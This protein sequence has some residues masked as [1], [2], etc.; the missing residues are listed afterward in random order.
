MPNLLEIPFKRTHNVPIRQT[1]REYI[2]ANH[3]DVHPDAFKWDINQWGTLRKQAVDRTV[4]VDHVKV[5]L[6]YHAQLVFILTKLPVDIGLDIPYTPLFSPDGPP[7]TLRNLAYERAAVLFNLAALYSQLAHREDRSTADGLKR[8]VAYFQSAAGTLSHLSTSAAQKLEASVADN[9]TI[10]EFSAPFLSALENLMLA[11]AQEGVWQRAVIDNLKNGVIAKLAAKAASF[12]RSTLQTIREASPAVMHLFPASW[13]A[14]VEI[15]ASHFEGVSQYRKS[16]DDNAAGRY[17]EEVGRLTQALAIVKKGHDL[18]RRSDVNEAVR[19]DIK[20]L[21]NTV[22]TTLRTSERDNDLIYHQVVPSAALLPPIAEVSMVQPII[23]G[24][25]AD[26]KTAIP[27][28][29]VI[30]GELLSH[31]AKLAIE[32]YHDR[33]KNWVDEEVVDRARRLDDDCTSVLGSLGLPAALEALEKPVGLPPSLLGKAEEVRREDGPSKI[34]A[35]IENVQK[36]AERNMDLLNE[37]FDILDQE[38]EEDEVFQAEAPAVRAPSSEANQ[39]LVAKAQRYKGILDGGM[40]SDA[41][42]REKWEQWERFITQLTW[43]NDELERAVPSSTAP[44]PANKP[45]AR[46]PNPTQ[47]HARQLRVLLE[48]LDD[49]QRSCAQV[50]T[51]ATRLSESEDIAPRIL[52]AAAAVERWVEVQPSMFEDVL[53]EE[54][55]K[56]E[57]FR[58]EIEGSEQ[59]QGRTLDSIKERNDLFL[60]CRKDD[61]SV[62]EREHALQSLD[63]AY[64]K[65]KEITRNL[66]EGLK[67][68]NDISDILGRLKQD[69]IEWCNHRRNEMQYVSPAGCLMD[70]LVC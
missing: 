9:E 64:H 10:L 32:I 30:F 47:G 25:L 22:Q 1:V 16:L 29:A 33:R 42:V 52:K 50:V 39:A 45:N 5:S 41:I 31:G 21:L 28:D 59:K 20:S 26:P 17:G 36:L 66:D 56:Y 4:H 34:E 58:A 43:S 68:Y 11:Q 49:L 8:T 60:Q 57:K 69:C 24:T 19:Q 40:Q 35:S 7:I 62:K 13:L 37:A 44:L 18:A 12:Y 38:A 48:T 55:A 2:L 53:D 63:L 54:L 65:Y 15:K 6:G 14:H 67:F 27:E 51:R 23:A 46:N 70:L 3:S 61:P